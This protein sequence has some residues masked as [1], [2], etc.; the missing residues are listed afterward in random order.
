M[1]D[2]GVRM[3]TGLKETS[4]YLEP[5]EKIRTTSVVIMKYTDGEDKHN[6]FRRLVKN[7]FSHKSFHPDCRDGLFAFALWGGIS[8]PNMVKRLNEL[9]AHG[10]RYEDVWIDAG[11]YG[12]CEESGCT[13]DEKWYHHVGEWD[14]SKTNH[15]DGLMDVKRAA[16]ENDMRLM[17]WFEIERAFIGTAVPKEHPEWFLSAEGELSYIINLGNR[18]AEQ[19]VLNTLSQ[20]IEK[21]DI[22]CYRQDFNLPPTEF[23]RS[24]DGENRRGI[25]EIKHITAMYRIW[26]T[27]LEKFPGLIIDNCASG[28]R[29]IDI[30]TMRRS[31]PLY[32]TDYHSTFNENAEVIQCHTANISSYLPY[33]GCVTKRSGGIYDIRSTYSSSW[34]TLF[35]NAGLAEVSEADFELAKKVC[36]EYR[37]IRRY[38][39]CDFYNHASR[40][41]D[42]TSWAVWQYHDEQTDSG[43]VLAFR[44]SNSPFK[45]VTV[46]LKGIDGNKRY[47]AEN[48][49]S[50][51]IF[52]IDKS[53][54]ITLPEK[55][56]C[57]IFEYKGK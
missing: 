37:R 27:L 5:Q 18:E 9:K 8:S 35:Y 42:D 56:S 24:G 12:N 49:D 7:H 36:D 26:D 17:L 50:G 31:V 52:D 38:F 20:H 28:G 6:K 19:Y 13:A 44:R 48:L 39:S 25:T 3:R 22:S 29:R 32:R 53:I 46:E 1:E 43:I 2:E 40:D 15:P 33:T 16:A 11:W 51:E 47:P 54:D 45:S 4:F 10:I 21:L 34:G 23:F 14:V 57:V 41:F 55:R 30:E